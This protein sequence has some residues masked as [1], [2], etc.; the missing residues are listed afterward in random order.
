MK[1]LLILA[2]MFFAYAAW[3]NDIYPVK[4]YKYISDWNYR[5]EVE[6][7][8]QYVVLVFSSKEC[9]ERTIVERQCFLFEK[10]FDYFIPQ[11]SSK[12]KV[13]GFNTYFENHQVVSQFNVKN[14][15]VILMKD[16]K[17]LKRIEPDFRRPDVVT[18]SWQDRLL[19]ETLDTL[20]QIH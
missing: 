13:V 1:G 17:I 2:A 15:A 8:K 12:L 20:R 16:G 9:L 18:G 11:L 19:K 3:S 5:E 6:D 10:K 4:N 14:Q 7:S